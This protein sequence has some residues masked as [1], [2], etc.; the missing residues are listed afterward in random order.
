MCVC[1]C[2]CVWFVGPKTILSLDPHPPHPPRQ[3]PADAALARG[4]AAL[5]D[6]T[7]ARGRALESLRGALAGRPA[8]LAEAEGVAA[9][10]GAAG[11]AT[12]ER[13]GALLADG[14]AALQ[15]SARGPACCFAPLYTL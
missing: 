6:E 13:V 12:A 8:L 4:A 9:A 7:A 3:G 10:A 14:A 11:G 15:V 1:V 2:V 5:A